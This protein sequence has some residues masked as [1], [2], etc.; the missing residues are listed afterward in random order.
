MQKASKEY[1]ESMKRKLR[2]Q[3]HIRISIGVINQA[4]QSDSST[5]ERLYTYFSNTFKPLNNYLVTD[6][7]ASFEKDFTGADGSQ[8]FLPRKKED[9]LYNAGLVPLQIGDAIEL[10]FGDIYDIR[11]LT[12]DF[13]YAYPVDFVIQTNNKR[14]EITGNEQQCFVTE[15]IFTDTEWLRLIPVTMLTGQCRMRVHQIS[16]GIGIYFDNVKVLSATKRGYISPI[17]EELPT[18]DLDVTVDNKDKMFN[19][20][21]V[22]SAVNFL[23]DGQIVEVLYGYSLDNG[24]VEWI[25]GTN[26][27]LREWDADDKEMSFTATDR[28][29]SMAGTYWRGKYR[30]EGISLYDLAADVFQDAGF[31]ERDYD[32]DSYLKN[33]IVKNPLPVAG[34]KEELQLIAN[35]GRC[36]IFQNR[37]GVICLKASFH[38]ALSP[39]LKAFSDNAAEHCNVQSIVAQAQRVRYAD[40]SRDAVPSD[41]SVYFF[42]RA[43]KYLNTGYVSREQSETDG[44]FKENPSVSIRLEAAAKFYGINLEFDGNMPKEMVIHTYRNDVLVE[45]FKTSVE[46]SIEHEFPEADLYV[47][48]FTRTYPNNRIFLNHVG[49]GDVT[50]YMLEIGA[51]LSAYPKGKQLKKVKKVSADIFRYQEGTEQRELFKDTVSG[52][53]Y[54]AYFS[55]PCH[56]FRVNTGTIVDSSDYFVTVSIPEGQETELRI[57]GY[58][59]ICNTITRTRQIGQ[60]GST[61]AFSNQLIGDDS[62]AEDYLDWLGDYFCS[63]V[64]YELPY[65]GEPRLDENDTVFLESEYIDNL[66]VR[67]F[68]HTLKFSQSISGTIK[69]RREMYVDRT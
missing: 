13:G 58:E 64:E 67:V 44:M 2:E 56:G 46:T 39:K 52:P 10:T 57:L 26:L 8:F 48:E 12:I 60:T 25:Q 15:E 33:V 40:F 3:S 7:Y 18:L 16:M 53:A 49:F 54:T 32:I 35:A 59:Y 22:N 50:D 29:D 4:A 55:V 31:E 21:N 51:D 37:E 27:L 23:E 20:E 24:R 38:V 17:S 45:S 69:A 6:V 1:K 65:R 63:Q 34:H 68:E 9:V 47:L 43:G 5:D 28:F 41:G 11:G 61:E 19:T 14:V 66:Q 42:P 62:M 30:P 36:I